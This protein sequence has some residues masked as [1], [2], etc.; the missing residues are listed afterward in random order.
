MSLYLC[1]K[2]ILKFYFIFLW[3]FSSLALSGDVL[4]VFRKTPLEVEG[5]KLLGGGTIHKTVSIPGLSLK[6]KIRAKLTGKIYTDKLF[7][8]QGS[9][10]EA[11]SYLGRNVRIMENCVLGEKVELGDEVCLLSD[12]HLENG[13]HIGDESQIGCCVL[14]LEKCSISDRVRIFGRK[15][16]GQG[17]TKLGPNVRVFADVLIHANVTVGA[18]CSI[19][20]HSVIGEDCHLGESVHIANHGCLGSAVQIADQVNIYKNVQIG[21]H[22]SLGS[23][24]VIQDGVILQERTHLQDGEQIT[25]DNRV[26]SSRNWSSVN[27]QTLQ[28]RIQKLRKKLRKMNLYEDSPRKGWRH[29]KHS[30]YDDEQYDPH[31][32]Q[33]DFHDGR[34]V[35]I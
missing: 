23:G 3:F 22:S 10:I 7:I 9:H 30:F 15:S 24:V 11:Y 31:P 27:P 26:W 14:I 28:D 8:G 16:N 19:S 17:H 1:E 25:L 20:S 5:Q 12:T 29:A 2:F 34:E 33:S 4:T 32:Y 6:Q 18:K 35:E 13:V 21:C